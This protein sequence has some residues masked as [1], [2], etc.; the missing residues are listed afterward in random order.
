MKTKL[1]DINKFDWEIK[2]GLKLLKV[3]SLSK[4][5]EFSLITI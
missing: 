2:K 5:L 1:L 3:S 4:I